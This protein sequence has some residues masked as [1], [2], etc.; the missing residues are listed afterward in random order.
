MMRIP[1]WTIPVWVLIAEFVILSVF[2]LPDSY[3]D[4]KSNPTGI[5]TSYLIFDGWGNI[6]TL[7]WSTLTF[8]LAVAFVGTYWRGRLAVTYLVATN[9]SGVI[10]GLVYYES[11][12]SFQT[13]GGMSA[14]TFGALALSLGLGVVALANSY[15]VFH[16]DV[17][18]QN[19]RFYALL[20]FLIFGVYLI[21]DAFTGFVG[22]PGSLLIHESGILVGFLAGTIPTHVII[23]RARA[24][25]HPSANEGQ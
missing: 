4:I 5:M 25:D 18:L 16:K 14:A 1:R 3:A 23:W 20:V 22:K 9:L 7:A 24:S 2:P 21:S 17:Y 13:G 12:Y 11:V 19:I 10:A 15:S 6:F 8:L